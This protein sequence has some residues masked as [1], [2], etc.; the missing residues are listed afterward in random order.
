MSVA[1]SSR[2]FTA[3]IKDYVAA[4]LRDPAGGR[5]ALGQ[6]AAR[7]HAADDQLGALI[8]KAQAVHDS[9][10]AASKAVGRQAKAQ[11][12][13]LLGLGLAVITAATVATTRSL[14]GP[15]LAPWP[16][17]SGWPPGT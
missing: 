12:Y 8:D 17:W 6:I 1:S 5:R 3:F 13:A 2:D 10:F 16:A 7:N 9:T 4:S 15:L 11:A 14:R